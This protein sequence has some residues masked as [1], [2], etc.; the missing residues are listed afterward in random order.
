VARSPTS[1]P[2]HPPTSRSAAGRQDRRRSRRR[3]APES[4]LK[5]SVLEVRLLNLSPGGLAVESR[6]ALR[7]G[8][9]YRFLLIGEPG[10]AEP[11]EGRVLWCRLHRTQKLD[12]GDI[13]A[14]FRAGIE[15]QGA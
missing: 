7:I 6:E 5:S 12:D 9:Q 2:P 15:R 14:V 3:S 10:P 1:A 8:G 13:Q 4:R 11:F